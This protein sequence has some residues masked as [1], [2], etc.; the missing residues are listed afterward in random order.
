VSERN[1]Q[2]R[3]TA[4]RQEAVKLKIKR[5]SRQNTCLLFKVDTLHYFIFTSQ[6][7]QI[8]PFKKQIAVTA[9]DLD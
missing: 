7:K 3:I 9:R 8:G 4:E 6:E 2:F 1:S 5:S